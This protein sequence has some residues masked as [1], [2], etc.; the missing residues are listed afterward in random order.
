MNPQPAS[1]NQL[2]ASRA[3]LPLDEV[4]AEALQGAGTALD[5][6]DTEYVIRA[7]L[8]VL[9]S[10]GAQEYWRGLEAGGYFARQ[11]IADRLGLGLL[12]SG[13]P[14]AQHEGT[15]PDRAYEPLDK[16]HRVWGFTGSEV[17]CECDP[18]HWFTR[19][20]YAEHVVAQAVTNLTL[21]GFTITA[22]PSASGEPEA[23]R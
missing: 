22:P 6:S 1:P 15:G 2:T 3:S 12:D 4:L 14:V 23:G 16:H 13:E 8:P 9:R 5:E 21:A 18:R 17:A 11:K 20:Q 19:E 10:H 7:V